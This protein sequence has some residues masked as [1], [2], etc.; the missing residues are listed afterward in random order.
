[1][2]KKKLIIVTSLILWNHLTQRTT[3]LVVEIDTNNN[4]LCLH[5]NLAPPLSPPI[6]KGPK[7]N[8]NKVLYQDFSLP[9]SL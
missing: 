7:N 6:K 9:L 1:M 2:V 8:E 5:H 4:F 3:V